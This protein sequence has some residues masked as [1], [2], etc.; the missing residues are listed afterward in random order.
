MALRNPQG[1][2]IAVGL[3]NYAAADVE[4][5]RGRRSSEIESILGYEFG[6]DVVHRNNLALS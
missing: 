3:S 4:R 1:E 5:I 2:Q 6:A